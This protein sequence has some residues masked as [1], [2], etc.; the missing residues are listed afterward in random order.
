MGPHEANE[1]TTITL[2][3]S[4]GHRQETLP[5]VTAGGDK[6]HVCYHK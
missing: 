1:T 4:E 2:K 3:G 5:L 6:L